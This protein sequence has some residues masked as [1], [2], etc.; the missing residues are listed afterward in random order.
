M[1]PVRRAL[2]MALGAV[3]IAAVT[4]GQ[5]TGCDGGNSSEAG[6]P[7]LTLRVT[8][9]GTSA[10]FHGRV[11]FYAKDGQPIFYTPPA[12]DGLN[13]DVKLTDPTQEI[14]S[15][16]LPGKNTQRLDSA[17]L[18]SLINPH[19]YV[20]LPKS[21]TGVRILW[22]PDRIVDFNVVITGF[23][24]TAGILLDVHYNPTTKRFCSS[25]TLQCDTLEI[26]V[27][28]AHNY[29]GRLDTTGLRSRAI[30]LFVPGTPYYAQVQA[31]SFRLEG[32]PAGKLPL[33]LVTADG[34][35]REM[36]DSAGVT[37]KLP[38]VPGKIV[39]SLV[40]PEKVLDLTPVVAQPQG[41]YAFTDSVTITLSAEKGAAIFYTLDG[42]TPDAN[43]KRY[44]GPIVLRASSTL[45]AIAILK[46]ANRSPISVNNYELVPAPPTA[47]PASA[48]FRDSVVVRLTAPAAGAKVY[49]TLDGSAP[50]ANNSLYSVPIVIKSTTTLKAVAV[51]SGLGNSR[52][53]EEKYVLV[54]DSAGTP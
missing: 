18:A 41:Q 36:T 22:E 16:V 31:D 35:V 37:W 47:L 8:E 46:G 45:K 33:L 38:L 50:T 49:F 32:L 30:T 5:L 51:Q 20:P 43:T 29:S 1:R 24:T 12:N 9:S 28:A 54:K 34:R 15:V 27:A 25:D 53:T 52:V 11:R 40:L 19:P 7:E 39:D 6:N 26:P 10:A 4:L 2:G 17:I 42:A 21:A 13:P 3:G 48:T 23:D 14:S 44:T